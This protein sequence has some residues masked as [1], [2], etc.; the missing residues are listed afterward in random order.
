M[1]RNERKSK[2]KNGA[3]DEE[4]REGNNLERMKSLFKFSDSYY[5]GLKCIMQCT[6]HASVFVVIAQMDLFFFSF[7]LNNDTIAE[8]TE[9]N[10]PQKQIEKVQAAANSILCWLI[11]VI[12]YRN[13]STSIKNLRKQ[14]SFLF[15]VFVFE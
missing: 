8:I 12:S 15:F 1:V 10:P 2:W 14:L 6:E 3:A 9:R 4:K 11:T 5:L 13:C 7:S